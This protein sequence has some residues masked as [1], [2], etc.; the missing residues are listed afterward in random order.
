MRLA[1]VGPRVAA[2]GALLALAAPAAHPAGAAAEPYTI[3][4]VL[5][6]S[7]PGSTLGRPEADSME[8]AVDEI[9]RAGGVDGHPLK[10][11]ILDDQSDA[12]TAVNDMRQ[13]LDQHPIAVFG[14]PLTPTSLAIV[15][16]AQRAEVPLVSYASSISVVTPQP[17][18]KWIFKIP[19]NDT[20]VARA[21]QAF[22]KKRNETKV[23]FIYRDDDYGK[24]G[25]AHFEDVGKSSGFDVVSSDAIAPAASDATTQLTHARGAHP[26]AL[27][28]WTTL[29]SANVIVK[30]YREL[31]LTVP[32]YYSDGAATGVFPKQAGPALDGA[33]IATLKVNVVDQLAA[34]DPQKKLLDAYVSAFDKGYPKDAPASIFGTWGYDGVGFLR[35]ALGEVKGPVTPASLRDAM[36]RTTFTGVSGT[37]HFTP[38]QHY[39]LSEGA[40]VMSQIQN[41]KF[42]LVR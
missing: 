18:K 35:A 10:L 34:N 24:T 41:G 26:Q 25:L 42:S 30:G 19:I 40:V 8:L 15:P 21:M 31:G 33:Y 1:S 2:I 14:T 22:M 36:E 37:F 7:G 13:L 32:L 11:T 28:C 5:S 6:E 16:L 4:A 29:P 20:E 23:S 3:G 38:A 9:N 17:D 27:I 39:G 12:T